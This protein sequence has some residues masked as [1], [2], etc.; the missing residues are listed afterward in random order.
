MR[1]VLA[2]ASLLLL[3]AAPLAAPLASLAPAP[4]LPA[5]QPDVPAA[6]DP[7][8]TV[9]AF[10]DEVY[11]GTAGIR[12]RAIAVPSDWDR[13]VLVFRE[14]PEGDPWDR[15]FAAFVGG[16]EVL[17]GTTPRTDMT[18]SKDVTEFRS[19]L[20]EG[21]VADLG[22]YTDTYVGAMVVS[23]RVEFY[24]D[25][26]TGALASPADSVVA[27]FTFRGV[28]ADG[29]ARTAQVQFPATPPSSAEVELYIT[30]HGAAEFW[31][32][33][34]LAPR[35]FRV[36]VDGTEVATAVVMPYTYAFVGFDGTLG[37]THGP[38]WWTAQRA[39]DLAGVPDG[40][41]EIPPY[42][43]T[44]IGDHLGLLAGA[45]TISLVPSGGSCSW[46][47]SVNFLLHA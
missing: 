33:N 19:L 24:R 42:R 10:E 16:V 45:R 39:M 4:A 34:G 32:L 18:V 23:A 26:P 28:C 9:W 44:L 38:V 43:A 46:P 3:L 29:Q 22:I 11:S 25:E 20:P 37:A 14:R 12:T 5:V 27:P 30:G 40:V 7:I 2:L 36:L 8:A 17:R 1:R 41:G 31:Y 35:Y 21:G 6:T 47:T 13:A 15:L